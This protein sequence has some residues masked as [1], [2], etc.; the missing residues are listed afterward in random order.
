MLENVLSEC[1][2]VMFWDILWIFVDSEIKIFLSSVAHYNGLFINLLNNIKELGSHCDTLAHINT[3]HPDLVLKDVYAMFKV[4]TSL[5]INP[6][7][8]GRESYL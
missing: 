8:M 3:I 5:I 4:N 2:K 7:W 1:L 6:N